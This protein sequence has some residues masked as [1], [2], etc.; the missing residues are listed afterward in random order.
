MENTCPVSRW[1]R[2]RS[3]F[4]IALLRFC[5]QVILSDSRCD[6]TVGTWTCRVILWT[7]CGW[8][9]A[10]ATPLP[11]SA[12]M[13][14]VCANGKLHPTGGLLNVLSLVLSLF[15]SPGVALN[16]FCSQF[17]ATAIFRLIVACECISFLRRFWTSIAIT[18][19][20]F[21][22]LCAWNIC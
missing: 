8:Q 7:C 11:A 16:W 18:F 4:T 21:G 14:F 12:N 13:L 15:W 19:L 3:F 5:L 2:H 17:Y 20:L 22:P 6:M 1:L 10:P 9:W